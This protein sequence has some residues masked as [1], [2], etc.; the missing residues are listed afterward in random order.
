ML[1]EIAVQNLA[2]IESARLEMSGRLIAITGETGAGKSLVVDAIGL[3]LG[4]R[5]DS[6]RVASGARKAVISAVFAVPPAGTAEAELRAQGFELEEGM[7]FLTREIT[8]EGRSTCRING[9]AAPASAAR[10]VGECLVDLHGQHEHQTLLRP[11]VHRDLLDAWLGEKAMALRQQIGDCYTALQDAEKRIADLESRSR[12]R[13]RLADLLRF[14]LAEIE[15]ADLTP[16]EEAELHA[17]RKR[18]QNAER[19]SG[20]VTVA[21][22]ALTAGE[23]SASDLLA[24]AEAAL[25]RAASL[26]ERLTDVLAQVRDALVSAQEA[27]A[28]LADYAESFSVDPERVAIVEDRLDLLH[29]LQRKYGATV[30]EVLAYAEQA[31]ANLAD[32]EGGEEALEAL[33]EERDARRAEMLA[34][35]KELTK[36]R[37]D[38]A[39]RFEKEALRHIRDLAMEQAA[40]EVRLTPKEPDAG[41]AESVEFLFSANPGH[42]P[43]PL[44]RIASGGELSRVMLALRCALAGASPAPTI[45]YDEVDAGLGGQVAAVVG[46]KLRQLA[47][48]SQVIVITHLAQIAGRADEQ[49]CITKEALDGRTAVRVERL[50]GEERVRELARMLSGDEARDTALRHARELL[51]EV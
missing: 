41:G 4:D 20:E 15:G 6:Q 33:R 31:R 21:L 12:E 5:A 2:V 50:E 44:G 18:I 34:A 8:P 27:G 23:T 14:E 48:H 45:V 22:D 3:A 24:T 30:E 36:L 35:C 43:Q 40:F 17:E 38:G 25:Q 42:P 39:P 9:H 32:L 11:V 16:G 29:R 46:D 37:R 51:A 10:T 28:T 26:D 7:L 1:R 49:F 13:E 47:Q 19:L